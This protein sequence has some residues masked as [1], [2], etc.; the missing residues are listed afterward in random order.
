[1][2]KS[3]GTRKRAWY[4]D[5]RGV[6]TSAIVNF[7][8]ELRDQY[9]MCRIRGAAVQVDLLAAEGDELL[10]DRY[11]VH[12]GQGQLTQLLFGC[13]DGAGYTINGWLIYASRF[14]FDVVGVG[15]AGSSR[16]QKL[17]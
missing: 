11:G 7:G 1:M 15:G 3:S 8:L 16:S 4:G 10:R 5:S 9:A 2:E 17:R 13:R 14:A 6:R 12:G